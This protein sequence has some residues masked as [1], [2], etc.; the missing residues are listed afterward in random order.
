M[1]ALDK[2]LY[3][4][5]IVSTEYSIVSCAFWELT[6]LGELQC[7]VNFFMVP[8]NMYSYMHSENIFMKGILSKAHG[9]YRPFPFFFAPQIPSPFLSNVTFFAET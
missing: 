8:N 4:L 5:L 3:S 6:L 1:T 2:L 7:L 9:L